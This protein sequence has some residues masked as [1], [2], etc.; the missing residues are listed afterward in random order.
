M[1]WPG[2]WGGPGRGPRPQRALA[3]LETP[4]GRG[5]LPR[6]GGVGKRSLAPQALRSRPAL[7]AV[8]QLS[9]WGPRGT[10]NMPVVSEGAFKGPVP[11]SHVDRLSKCRRGH[12]QRAW[13]SAFRKHA[14][15]TDPAVQGLGKEFLD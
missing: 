7:T 6:K 12:L 10:V 13:E 15:K 3:H 4:G 9:R 1:K 8:S 11:H 5:A 2:A 14:P